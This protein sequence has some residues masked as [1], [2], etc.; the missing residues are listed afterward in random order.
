MKLMLR[1]PAS[2]AVDEVRVCAIDG[3]VTQLSQYRRK[4]A[5]LCYVH[6]GERERRAVEREM[7]RLA[8]RK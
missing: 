2:M 5:H 3:C 7:K 8:K 4:N 1:D 6:E